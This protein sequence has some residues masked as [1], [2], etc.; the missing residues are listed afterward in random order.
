MALFSFLLELSQGLPPPQG[1]G[2]RNCMPSL[3]NGESERASEWQ[4]GKRLQRIT[5]AF[6]HLNLI[7]MDHHVKCVR[8]DTE[9]M[10]GKI[11][12]KPMEAL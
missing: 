1:G 4:L 5:L 7:I 9:G 3:V 12:D 2:S 10:L 11:D 6:G 8:A